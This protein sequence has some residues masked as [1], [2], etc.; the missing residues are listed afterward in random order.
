[1]HSSEPFPQLI[2]GFDVLIIAVR[3]QQIA[4]TKVLVSMRRPLVIKIVIAVIAFVL[5]FFT[6][7]VWLSRQQII[8]V[9]NHLFL[10]YQD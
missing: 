8:G 5:G 9:L 6:H 1:M 10:Y 4:A 2:V 3:V 7:M